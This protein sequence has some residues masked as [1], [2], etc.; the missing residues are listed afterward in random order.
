MDN[1]YSQEEELRIR[2]QAVRN[3]INQLPIE[4]LIWQFLD[5]FDS[6]YQIYSEYED[7][8]MH[9]YV[10]HLQSRIRDEHLRLYLDMMVLLG[11]LNIVNGY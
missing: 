2:C 1:D 7:R 4:G 9:F 10:L 11:L 3:I 8:S 6:E 5:F